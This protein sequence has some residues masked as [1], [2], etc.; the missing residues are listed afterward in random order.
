MINYCENTKKTIDFLFI[1]FDFFKLNSEINLLNYA[2]AFVS[3]DF[4][5]AYN[6]FL[7]VTIAFINVASEVELVVSADVSVLRENVFAHGENEIVN[8]AFVFA[9]SAFMLDNCAL[10]NVH[11]AYK[12]VLRAT[13][14]VT[15]AFVNVISEVELVVS[16]DAS[17]LCENV[18]AYGENKFVN[19]AFVFVN[20]ETVEEFYAN[21]YANVDYLSEKSD[22][23]KKL[24]ENRG[25]L[26]CKRLLLNYN[27]F[28][29]SDLRTFRKAA[30]RT[31]S[32]TL[33]FEHYRAALGTYSDVL[34]LD[35]RLK[36][37]A[38][39]LDNRAFRK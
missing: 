33:R 18:F 17:V 13:I 34:K 2:D 38:R 12:L 24:P 6:E 19:G 29:V 23:I 11:R 32:A 10:I 21:L 15:S 35:F 36:L 20:A 22:K 26:C 31:C 1:F 28:N 39:M 25:V 37:N 9:S 3:S 8:C 4:L 7:F 16:A 30:R 14:F 5:F 27:L